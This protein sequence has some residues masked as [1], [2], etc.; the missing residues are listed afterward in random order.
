RVVDPVTRDLCEGFALGVN[1]WIAEHPRETPPWCEGVRPADPLALWHAFL[2]SMAPLDLPELYRRP[3]AM[4]T[5]NAWA[6]APH[7]TE[8]G[9]TLLVI[10]PHDH[11]E[12][13]FR[14]YEAHLAVG[15][16]D[17]AGVTLYGLPVIV[18]GHNGY[19]GWAITPNWPDF[20]DVYEEKFTPPPRNP[21]DPRTPRFDPERLLTL[22]F[23]SNARPYYVRTPSGVEER[24]TPALISGRGPVFQGQGGLYSWRVGGFRDFG[25]FY[26]LMEMARAR[27]LNAFQA[28][29][30]LHQLPC[31]HVLY[32]DR[33]GNLF[34]VYNT[35]A[36]ARELPTELL[37]DREKS[38]RL[39]I[40]WQTP[41]DAALDVRA[42][43]AL[44]APDRLPYVMN[45]SSGYLQ[46]CGNPPWTAT[47]NSGLA[48]EAWPPWLVQDR[49]TPRA[50]RVR[51]LLRT[52]QRGFRDMQSMVYDALAPA[53]LELTPVLL[54]AADRRPDFVKAAH[55]DLAGGLA[56]LRAWSG[57]ADVPL[58]GMTFYHVWWTGLTRRAAGAFPSQGALHD[59]LLR[60]ETNAVE[61]ALGAAAD[62]ARTLRNE[63]DSVA[64]PWGQVHRI[65][66]GAR[67]E[68]VGGAASGDPVFLLSD[69]RLEQGKWYADYGFAHAFVIEFDDPPRAVSVARFGVS[70][71]P[72][73]PHFDDQ[74]DLML[75]RRFKVNRFTRDEVWRYARRAY[76]RRVTLFPLGV[77]GAFTFAAPRE[78][79]A[80]LRTSLETTG[81]LPEGM[82]AFSSYVRPYYEPRTTPVTLTVEM[83]VP[84]TLCRAELL[85]HLALYVYE[86][87]LSW[88]PLSGQS[89]DAARRRLLGTHDGLGTYAVL[90]PEW[91][92]AEAAPTEETA[93]A[94][95]EPEPEALPGP[96][97]DLPQVWDAS[98]QAPPGKFQ[99]EVLT[100]IPEKRKQDRDDATPAAPLDPNRDRTFRIEPISGS[101]PPTPPVSP[102]R[103]ETT[104]GTE[105]TEGAE[106]T[107]PVESAAPPETTAPDAKPPSDEPAPDTEPPSED[108][109]Q[110]QPPSDGKPKFRLER[111]K[112][113]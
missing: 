31:F 47:D 24:Y 1:A 58:E 20:A 29:L 64:A 71:S 108:A 85:S 13:P 21:A 6:I 51:R 76:G 90:G 92:R 17:V 84:E 30:M 75:E 96:P 98:E 44:I 15:D 72:N 33:A 66:R 79:A 74:L 5:G 94:P 106:A 11:F 57:V 32:A 105:M 2:M 25:G 18:Q 113:E 35:K 36:G 88:R 103:T 39:P 49:D 87:G 62:A 67:E 37:A 8:Q 109:A 3:R 97:G 23:M 4:D 81:P 28:A 14:W 99:F 107:M 100:P 95:P 7:R 104:Q 68:G 77:T 82:A 93:P 112:R 27:D 73:A 22:E 60:K 63:F 38:G 52:G 102:Q 41:E 80:T 86:E 40:T 45:P 89:V 16:V 50:Q 12:G 55:P 83:E 59:A 70:D 91:C 110:P 48:P 69:S 78:I 54:E 53:A 10:N 61:L 101:A 26:Q 65:R 43:A 19:S 34:Y 9:K 42:W 111:L 56:L 46:V